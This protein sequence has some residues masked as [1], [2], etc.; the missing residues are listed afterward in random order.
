[1][2][3]LY[4]LAIV[5]VIFLLSSCDKSPYYHAL[6]IAYPSSNAFIYADQTEDSICFVTWD[7]YEVF[8]YSNSN[9]VKV[10]D[11][12]AYPARKV[13]PNSYYQ[14]YY[15]VVMLQMEPNTTGECRT[16]YVAVR[17]Y[18]DQ[19]WN[20]TAYG[21][22]YQF[23]WHD[24]RRPDPQYQYDRDAQS[25]KYISG[26]KFELCDSATQQVDTL[27]FNAYDRWT[28][29]SSDETVVVPQVTT[30]EAG[31]Q[32]ILLTVPNPN[33]GEE[34]RKAEIVLRSENGAVTRVY[35]T[36]AGVKK[37]ETE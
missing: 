11:S 9:W 20:E 17:S 25:S 31:Q 23:N 10:L 16:G 15:G 33:T 5:A 18:G 6:S 19:D 36:Q 35:F 24:I 2:K 27:R 26:V 14:Y 29:S 1:M 21:V 32:R 37:K 34:E 22:Y 30:G 7:S 28:L 4:S 13:I 3:H 8:P 12:Q